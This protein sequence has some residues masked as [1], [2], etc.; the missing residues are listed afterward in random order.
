MSYTYTKELELL[1]LGTLLPAYESWQKVKGV[2][3]PYQ[4]INEHLLKQIKA[5]KKLPALLRPKENL[6]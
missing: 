1:I 4:G 5:K 2:V 6:S 3:N